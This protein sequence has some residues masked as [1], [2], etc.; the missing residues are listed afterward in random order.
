MGFEIDFLA[1]GEE[2]K[3]GDAI[4][5][6]WGDLYGDASQQ[7][8]TLIDGG[9][10][11]TSDDIVNHLAAYYGTRTIDLMVSTHPDDDHIR[12]LIGVMERDD[13]TVSELWLHQ[14]WRQSLKASIAK[15]YA[16]R[17]TAE[18]G[19]FDAYVANARKLYDLAIERGATVNE[20][21]VGVV[22]GSRGAE[23]AV[24]GPSREYYTELVDD[25][26]ASSGVDVAK[27]LWGGSALAVA[28]RGVVAKVKEGLNMEA[29]TDEGTTSAA[30]NSSV[31]LVLTVAGQ[32]L[33]FTGD[34]GIP[35]LS[36]AVPE[37]ASRTAR[38]P[39]ALVQVPHHGSRHNV[40]PT[41]LDDLLGPAGTEIQLGV[42]VCSAA[43]ENPEAKRPA[44]MVT[45][46]FRRRGYP[47]NVTRGKGFCFFEDAP[48]RPG[49]GP[50]TP[51]PLHLEVENFDRD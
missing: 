51:D 34:A 44:K 37:V 6:R 32:H 31:M 25:F 39:V 16:S 42:S 21:F 40:G 17:E 35:A 45:N 1:V 33:L 12:G 18:R 38:T 36:R 48:F 5:L 11:A 43:A 29:L 22:H 15:K 50:A 9:F 2:S 41:V 10:A 19:S 28:V 7:T 23:I 27:G 14:P 26:G 3:S 24:A 4:L 30:N 49:W 13:V 46:A 20:P 8:V 47:T